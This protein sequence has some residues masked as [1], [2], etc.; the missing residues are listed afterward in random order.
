MKQLFRIVLQLHFDIEK[1]CNVA[2][3]NKMRTHEAP[4][5]MDEKKSLYQFLRIQLKEFFKH[6][7][8]GTNSES[9]VEDNRR[10]P[11]W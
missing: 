10:E 5:N 2:S 7:L 9:G 6:M 1:F 4:I 3:A 11:V 8:S